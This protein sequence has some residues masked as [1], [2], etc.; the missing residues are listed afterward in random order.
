MARRNRRRYRSY[1]E[2]SPN[3]DGRFLRLDADDGLDLALSTADLPSDAT[4]QLS[5]APAYLQNNRMAAQLEQARRRAAAAR[6]ETEQRRVFG[7]EVGDEVS[8]CGPML[9]VVLSL[10]G[11]VDYELVR[12]GLLNAP[13]IAN[14]RDNASPL[15]C[16]IHPSP[17]LPAPSFPD[18]HDSDESWTVLNLSRRSSASSP[19]GA[20]TILAHP[21]RE[22]YSAGDDS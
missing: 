19:D 7:G 8:L 5:A 15:A 18:E 10:F 17:S 1:H 22:E 21:T 12:L 20:W 9:Q 3:K 4:L 6:L 11:G 2:F 16:P 13:S 14:S